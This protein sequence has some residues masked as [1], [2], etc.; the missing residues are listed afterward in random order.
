MFIFKLLGIL[1][2]ITA[3]SI[4]LFNFGIASNRFMISFIAYLILKGLMFKGDVASIL[5]LLIALYIILMFILPITI[6]SIIT[7]LYLTQKG[8]LSLIS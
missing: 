7:A 5:D 4:I 3:I 1:D 8:F 2:L 6:I